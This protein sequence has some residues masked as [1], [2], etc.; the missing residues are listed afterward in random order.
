MQ[1]Y[2][3]MWRGGG[4]PPAAQEADNGG[5]EHGDETIMQ[6]YWM[7]AGPTGGTLEKRDV[8][9]P[10]PGPGQLLVRLHAAS[11]NRGEFLAAREASAAPAPWK[12]AGG[13]G[14]GEI[15]Q[16][17]AGVTGWRT[18]DR[19]MGRCAGAF[20][21]YARDGDVRPG[22]AQPDRFVGQQRRVL[23]RVGLHILVAGADGERHP[24]EFVLPDRGH[25]TADGQ[26]ADDVG[27]RYRPAGERHA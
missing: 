5:P 21:E 17:G 6:S 18:G 10:Q 9:V 15:A 8:P 26:R 1:L 2:K 25:G 7:Q 19:V 14:A 27:N 3:F 22:P 16:L 23:G 4:A 20:A 13:E 12:P 24:A 11:L